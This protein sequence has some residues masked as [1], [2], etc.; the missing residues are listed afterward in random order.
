VPQPECYRLERRDWH[1]H[2]RQCASG[3]GQNIGAGDFSIVPAAL[4]S[5][6][7]YVNVHTENFKAGDPVFGL[8]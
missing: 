4:L 3:P 1:A 7:A 6:T 8:R 5:D 2:S